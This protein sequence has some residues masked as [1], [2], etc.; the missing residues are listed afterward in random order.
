MILDITR[1][2]N[3]ILICQGIPARHGIHQS[4]LNINLTVAFPIV[5][6]YY[7]HVKE[8]RSSITAAGIAV[9]RAIESEKPEGVRICYD[10]YAARLLNPL[11]Y[12]FMRIFIDI[13]YAERTGPGVQGFLVGRCRYI[14]DFLQASL[15]RG[16]EQ[17]VILGA[18][19]DSRPYRFEQLRCGVK[20]F[21]VDHPATQQVKKN[22]VAKIFGEL[23]SHVTYVGVDFNQDTLE[24]RLLDFGYAESLKT[25]FIWEGVVMYLS[26]QAVESTLS[27]IAHHSASGSQV[28]FDYMYTA[29]LDGSV[30]HGEVSRLRRARPIS[31]EGLTFSIQD[32]Q[33]QEFLQEVGFTHIIDIVGDELHKRY[34]SGQNTRRKVAWGYGIASGEVR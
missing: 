1:S 6:Y 13:G 5:S 19:Y 3:L 9:V 18:G 2:V 34:F 16:L 20:V 23:P 8:K 12:H 24:K 17:L 32:G 27:F 15:E 21:E 25:L 26:S 10:P 30:R 7:I 11:F 14:D 22:K 29:L 4:G 33:A 28:I 31:G